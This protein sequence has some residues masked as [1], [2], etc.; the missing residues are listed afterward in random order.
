MSSQLPWIL[1]TDKEFHTMTMKTF[2]KLVPVTNEV[3]LASQG[4]IPGGSKRST[5]R[6]WLGFHLFHGLEDKN[7]LVGEGEPVMTRITSMENIVATLGDVMKEPVGTVLALSTI[8]THDDGVIS[9]KLVPGTTYAGGDFEFGA[10]EIPTKKPGVV[11]RLNKAMT[12]TG[13]MTTRTPLPIQ[14]I[15]IRASQVAPGF[16]GVKVP[17]E[18]VERFAKIEA[19]ISSRKPLQGT[20]ISALDEYNMKGFPKDEFVV[21]T[22]NSGVQR[23]KTIRQILPTPTLDAVMRE[24]QHEMD[25]IGRDAMAERP[26]VTEAYTPVMPKYTSIAEKAVLVRPVEDITLTKFRRRYNP[27]A[28]QL[29]KGGPVYYNVNPDILRRDAE[30]ARRAVRMR[31]DLIATRNSRHVTV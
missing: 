1:G 12:E 6:G 30:S 26:E 25:T 16:E 13:R 11:D 20:G 22:G 27:N 31:G 4:K 24:M 28:V 17:A 15:P 5:K 9:A 8:L 29:R 2:F 10:I 18:L 19:A 7:G 23:G 3:L 14:N 21:V